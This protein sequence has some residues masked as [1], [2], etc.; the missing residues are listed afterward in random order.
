MYEHVNS[1]QLRLNCEYIRTEA[2]ALSPRMATLLYRVNN[3]DRCNLTLAGSDPGG[4]TKGA[5]APP[6][7]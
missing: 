6:P 4:G 1:F 2:V 3:S 7:S 5:E